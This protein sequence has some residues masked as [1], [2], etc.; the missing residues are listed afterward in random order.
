M[1][2]SL[3]LPDWV[4]AMP[5]VKALRNM[6]RA[7]DPKT[8]ATPAQFGGDEYMPPNARP[9][10]GFG[11]E[12]WSPPMPGTQ[13][14]SDEV[15][16]STPASMDDNGGGASQVGGGRGD[17]GFMYG[18]PAIVRAAAR[19]QGG[20]QTT[21]GIGLPAAPG[22]APRGPVAEE[23]TNP[24]QD[25][26]SAYDKA[27]EAARARVAAILAKGQG[28]GA[29]DKDKWLSLALAGAHMAGS[30]SPTFFGGLGEGAAAGL[31]N[32]MSADQRAKQNA[33]RNTQVELEGEGMAERAGGQAENRV[34]RRE[35]IK[36]RS[37]ARLDALQAR[38]EELEARAQ[39]RS[40]DREARA[41]AARLAAETRTEI[42]KLTSGDRR[43]SADQRVEAAKV[44]AQQAGAK[45]GH[46]SNWINYAVEKGMVP[47]SPEGY[48]AAL[49]M[50]RPDKTAD[51][52]MRRATI[53]AKLY[54]QFM[55]DPL[56]RRSETEKR[57]AA[58][59]AANE[60]VR[61]GGEEA[62]AAA[63]AAPASTGGF[64]IRRLP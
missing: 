58:Q 42:A 64:S 2:S 7:L 6:N 38:K 54:G 20:G 10:V 11:G 56:D 48:K 22:M 40:L 52:G 61:G 43:Y 19:G 1:T 63:P 9:P 29:S 5:G 36:A 39:D 35:D 33:M 27:S 62:P 26:Q 23:A 14:G 13:S 17:T 25:M 8:Y 15:G 32:Y 4:Y 46:E 55:Q 37:Q 30:R 51:L 41:D 60:F 49:G 28:A 34:I 53:T 3:Q 45:G 12:E 18:V 44:R 31:Q 57:A 24:E 50:I 47:D 21:G 16:V 59:A